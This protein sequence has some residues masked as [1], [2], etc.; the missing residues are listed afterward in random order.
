MYAIRLELG[1]EAEDLQFI[2]YQQKVAALEREA[3]KTQR[4]KARLLRRV[5]RL[6][7]HL[8]MLCGII[9]F[10]ILNINK[11]N[12]LVALRE[13]ISHRPVLSA[14]HPIIDT[15]YRE[16]LIR[17][18]EEEEARKLL[19]FSADETE[20][21]DSVGEEVISQYAIVVDVNNDKIIAARDSKT[22]MV[23]ASMTKIMTLL[24]AAE[25]IDESKLDDT[26]T[27]T[28]DITYYAYK[29]DC[30]CVGFSDDEEVTVRDLLYGTI[31][32]SGGDAALALAIYVADSQEA[33]VELMNQK[34]ET[35]G[36]S[37]T[38]HFTNCVGLFDNDH[39][40]TCYDLAMILHAAIENPLCKEVLSKHIYT[41]SSTTQHPDGIEISNWFLR[42]I[43]DKPVGGEVVCAKTGYVNESGNC[44]A[45]Y[46]SDGN[47]TDLI[48]VTGASTSSWRCIYDH[49]AL[50]RKYFPGYDAS[51]T[52]TAAE[53]AELAAA[54][55]E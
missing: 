18:Q 45:S 16:E 36:L 22:R 35:L 24:V 38:T 26:F 54:E 39:Y 21:T 37:D 34:L 40:S 43:E 27:I 5:V 32:P 17:Q 20:D 42:R 23:P 48:V 9:V 10:S 28:P 46:G 25:N 55:E 7:L 53:E 30:S 14:A 2:R 11:Y 50:Y 47:G 13:E 33:F 19:M 8:I 29:H 6:A 44:S 49:V 15:T 12:E 4:L 1:R 31:L 41:T 52:D 51:E 3:E